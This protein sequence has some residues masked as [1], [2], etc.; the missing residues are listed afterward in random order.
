MNAIRTVGLPMWR[1]SMIAWRRRLEK[2][3][4]QL[5]GDVHGVSI[6]LFTW[7]RLKLC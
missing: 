1:V 2:R 5:I 7:M 6:R 4:L 3:L